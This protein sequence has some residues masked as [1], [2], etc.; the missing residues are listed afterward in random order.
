MVSQLCL[1]QAQGKT[2]IISPGRFIIKQQR[3]LFR[4]VQAGGVAIAVEVSKGV[5]M[6]HSRGGILYP[7]SDRFKIR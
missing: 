5:A 6:D 3:Q 2:A 4:V 1:T 7:F